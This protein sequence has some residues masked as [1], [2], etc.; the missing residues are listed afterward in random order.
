[1]EDCGGGGATC[2][3]CFIEGGLGSS[4]STDTNPGFPIAFQTVR[5]DI[6]TFTENDYDAGEVKR[7]LGIDEVK[8]RD[9]NQPRQPSQRTSHVPIW[10]KDFNLSEPRV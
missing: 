8:E 9:S 2:L 3:Y 6:A 7:G 1:M 10:T 4:S 5:E